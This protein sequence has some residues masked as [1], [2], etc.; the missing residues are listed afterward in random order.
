[1]ARVEIIYESCKGCTLCVLNCPQECLKM[2]REFNSKG[3]VLPIF[4]GED[5]CTGC[6]ACARLCPDSALIVYATERAG[7][8]GKNR[9]KVVGVEI[10]VAD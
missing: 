10:E 2:G 6:T 7:S 5:Y 4:S 3:Y 1:M 8:T 9:Q